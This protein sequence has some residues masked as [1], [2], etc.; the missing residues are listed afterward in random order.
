LVLCLMRTSSAAT[1]AA[2]AT[3]LLMLLRSNFAASSTCLRSSSVK[4]TKVFLPRRGF[5]R[6]R[7]AAESFFAIAEMVSPTNVGPKG[8]FTWRVS[9]FDPF[10]KPRHLTGCCM[11]G[12]L[13][14]T[15]RAMWKLSWFLRDFGYDAELLGKNEVDEKALIDVWGVVKVSE[16]TVHSISLANCAKRR[17]K[18]FRRFAKYS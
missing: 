2:L 14:C 18:L 3:K 7:D 6:R 8:G 9:S 1:S 12:R 11:T 16:V 13:Y 15:P 4:Y 17:T 5:E 10:L